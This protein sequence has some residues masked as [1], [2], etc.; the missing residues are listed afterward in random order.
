MPTPPFRA[1]HV[2]SL[3]RPESVKLARKAFYEEG[4]LDV[5][6]L[7]STEDEAIRNLIRMQEG[8]GL[9]AVTDGEQ[10]RSFWHF[11][12]MG[13]LDG[14]TLEQREPE[15]GAQFSGVKLRP[16][17]PVVDGLLDFPAEH[18]HIALA[19]LTEDKTGEELAIFVRAAHRAQARVLVADLPRGAEIRAES[20]CGPSRASR[21][22][23]TASRHR[24]CPGTWPLTRGWSN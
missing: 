21:Y 6:G 15:A 13:F 9:K 24:P 16:T 10:R 20:R 17:I 22:S 12:F 1:D 19:S 8:V 2:G 11:D 14:L 4:T 18:P 3:L 23:W 5:E 7:R